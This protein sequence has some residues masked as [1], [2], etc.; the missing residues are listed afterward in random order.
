MALGPCLLLFVKAPLSSLKFLRVSL[1]IGLMPQEFKTEQA[2]QKV[3]VDAFRKQKFWLVLSYKTVSP[4]KQTWYLFPLFTPTINC[5][6]GVNCYGDWLF[7]F[8]IFIV[9]VVKEIFP[10]SGPI[11][12]INCWL[13]CNS[14]LWAQGFAWNRVIYLLLI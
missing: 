12:V 5:T 9:A 10:S 14:L 13:D 4:N 7:N 2:I 1:T 11:L 8:S 6:A 3:F